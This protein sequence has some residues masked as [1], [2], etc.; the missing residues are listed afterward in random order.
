MRAS[1][2]ND[3]GA[4][5]SLL[6]S[7]S[8]RRA[9]GSVAAFR[10]TRARG[11]VRTLGPFAP[12]YRVVVSQRITDRFGV[13]AIARGR[14]AYAV[15]LRL[16]RG[17]WRV[18]LPGRTSIEVLG[19]RPG[20][21]GAVFQVGVEVHGSGVGE[22]VVYL[23]GATLDP[24]IATAPSSATVFANLA[25]RLPRGRHTATVFVALGNNATA[26][27]WAFTAR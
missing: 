26:R 11:L 25:G 15:T 6:S 16:E 3:A 8:R 4:I 1:G 7:E 9:G 2:A 5:W 12:G 13:V 23:D 18:E 19:P 14:R 24:R 10:T 22:A 21:A 27:A 20:S 17:A